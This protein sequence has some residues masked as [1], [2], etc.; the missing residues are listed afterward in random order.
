MITVPYQCLCK[1][2]LIDYGNGNKSIVFKQNDVRHD[3]RFSGFSAYGSRENEIPFS[4]IIHYSL[5]GHWTSACMMHRVNKIRTDSS[6]LCILL[7]IIIILI[8][9]FLCGP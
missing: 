7:H 4:L 8:R 6:I 2:E 9:I 3:F 1:R 5:S